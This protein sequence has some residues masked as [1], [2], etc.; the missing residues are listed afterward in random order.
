MH[1]PSGI[2]PVSLGFEV[3]VK[4]VESARNLAKAIRPLRVPRMIGRD[5]V[6]ET[7]RRWPRARS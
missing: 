2:G 4:A 1:H 5:R 6:F 7:F 3:L